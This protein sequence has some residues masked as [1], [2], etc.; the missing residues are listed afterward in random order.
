MYVYIH[1]CV[2]ESRR[3]R[4]ITADMYCFC[5]LKATMC[6]LYHGSFY[7]MLYVSSLHIATRSMS[8]IAAIV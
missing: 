1:I 2:S 6:V 8:I 4:G 3:K 5:M 7:C